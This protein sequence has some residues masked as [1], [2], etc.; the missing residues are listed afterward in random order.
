MTNFLIGYLDV[1]MTLILIIK[2]VQLME[3]LEARNKPVEE[4]EEKVKVKRPLKPLP[5]NYLMSDAD[6]AQIEQEMIR[7]TKNMKGA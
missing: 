5:S 2:I 6:V 3:L 4:K 7:N 1:V